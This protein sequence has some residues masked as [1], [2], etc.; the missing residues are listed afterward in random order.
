[1]VAPE[2]HPGVPA[3]VAVYVDAFDSR[4]LFCVLRVCDVVL[5]LYFAFVALEF[6]PILLPSHR[7]FAVSVC[8]CPLV[9][10]E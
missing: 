9:V 4:P 2:P 1:M 8:P 5:L 3:L 6:G 10:D 7:A